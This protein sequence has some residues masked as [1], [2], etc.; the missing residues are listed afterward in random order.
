MENEK[1]RVAI[2]EFEN[3]LRECVLSPTER[4]SVLLNLGNAYYSL[5]KND[6]ALKNYDAILKLTKKVS[7]K[8]AREGEASALGNI[9]L[10]LKAKGDLDNALKYH[11]DALKI[12]QE[13]GY[14]QGEASAL[15]NI[16]L[17][18]SDKG[19]LD[20]ALKY[21]QDALKI[22][23]KFNLIYGRDIILNAIK[24]IEKHRKIRSI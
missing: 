5:S 21:F 2:E 14:K 10:I 16:G 15:G 23:D 13:I 17:I 3:M 7:E 24:L 12:D 22:L 8:D 20:N 18:Y 1:Y 4:M 11:Q 9:G 19:D 6:D